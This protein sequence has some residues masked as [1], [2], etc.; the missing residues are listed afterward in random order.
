M[1]CLL[2]PRLRLTSDVLFL[3]GVGELNQRVAKIHQ[4][5]VVQQRKVGMLRVVNVADAPT[6]LSSVNG[7]LSFELDAGEA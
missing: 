2:R 1:R 6:I 4:Q 7:F 3:A 5:Q